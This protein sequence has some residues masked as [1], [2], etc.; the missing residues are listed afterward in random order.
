MAIYKKQ[1]GLNGSTLYR[2]DGRLIKTSLVPGNILLLLEEQ[3]EVDDTTLDKLEKPLG[4]CIFCKVPTKFSRMVN[5][6]SL[7]VCEEH[8]HNMTLGQLAEQQRINEEPKVYEKV[9]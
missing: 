6:Q 3:P 4:K 1:A 9:E 8:Y 2:R 5:Q 7:A